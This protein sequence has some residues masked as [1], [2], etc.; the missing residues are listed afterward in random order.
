[1]Q[2]Q[3]LLVAIHSQ[4]LRHDRDVVHIA[5]LQGQFYNKVLQFWIRLEIWIKMGKS[6]VR[7]TIFESTRPLRITSTEEFTAVVLKAIGKAITGRWMIELWNWNWN[8]EK[9]CPCELSQTR[10]IICDKV[11]SMT[12]GMWSFVFRLSV[13]PAATKWWKSGW[14]LAVRTEPEDQ[15]DDENRQD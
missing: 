6:I 4:L 13:W 15:W 12:C 10:N 14:D 3:P 8:I 11:V 9:C 1:M 5:S 7:R 2:S